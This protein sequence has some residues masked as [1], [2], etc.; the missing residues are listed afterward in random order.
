MRLFQVVLFIIVHNSLW[1]L[2]EV[3]AETTLR[4]LGARGFGSHGVGSGE[5]RWEY[6]AV[7]ITNTCV[8]V[9]VCHTCVLGSGSG[10]ASEGFHS[11]PGD[12]DFG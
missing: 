3:G 1:K 11:V 7:F 6:D 2:C 10:C 9:C 4:G 5:K 12:S 8:C